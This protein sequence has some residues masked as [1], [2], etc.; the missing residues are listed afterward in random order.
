MPE[1]PEVETIKNELTPYVVG[2]RITGVTI[3]WERLVRQPSVM[4]FS[5]R[6][7]GQTITSLG[8]HGKYLVFS[9]S[10]GESLIIHLKMSGSLLIGK[11]GQEPPQYTR[12]IIRLDEGTIFFRDPRKFGGVWLV[13]DK[14]TVVGKL[15]PEP[16]ER[17]FTSGVL[18]QLLAK[19][20]AP[21][22]AVLVDQ[23]VIAGIGNMYADEAL[24]AA[25]IHPLRP[26]V[27]LSPGE[28]KRLH[29][30]IRQV[31]LAGIGNK[32]ASI[33]NY[34][35]PGGEVGTAHSEFNVAHGRRKNCP[36]CGTPIQRIVVRG[37]G[38]YLCPNCL[39]I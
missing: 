27:S 33:V 21:I 24:F 32:G 11:D 4:D 26:A 1:L 22:K 28:I 30:A 25:K 14:N 23:N 36:R 2:R 39:E 3:F 7:M 37:R 29:Q 5:A 9:L 31:L 6:L 13:T 8:R 12:A 34:Y 17:A 18:V 35:R 38:T 20:Q 16:L 15:G 10:N 19:R